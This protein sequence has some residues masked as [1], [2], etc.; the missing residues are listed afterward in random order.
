M[1][2]EFCQEQYMTA[3]T[4]SLNTTNTFFSKINPCSLMQ[5][6]EQNLHA[7]TWQQSHFWPRSLYCMP[8][9]E[10]WGLG[11]SASYNGFCIPSS[12]CLLVPDHGKK[13]SFFRSCGGTDNCTHTAPVWREGCSGCTFEEKLWRR[14]SSSGDKNVQSVWLASKTQCKRFRLPAQV[15]GFPSLPLRADYEFFAVVFFSFLN[16]NLKGTWRPLKLTLTLQVELLT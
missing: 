13:A 15:C 11:N 12:Y 4:R 2:K 16:G 1:V 8:G 9:L 3:P 6:T 10:I 14:L 5:N 7:L